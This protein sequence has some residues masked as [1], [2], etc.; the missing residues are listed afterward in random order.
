[1]HTCLKKINIVLLLC[2]LWP[3]LVDGKV[4]QALAAAAAR[5]G[6]LEEGAHAAGRAAPVP[7][8]LGG[9]AP[10]PL[11]CRWA[12]GRASWRGARALC[13]G[14]V[15]ARARQLGGECRGGTAGAVRGV[16][17]SESDWGSTCACT[18][19]ARRFLGG[20]LALGQQMGCV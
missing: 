16:T 5:R 17:S 9:P 14:A 4:G 10:A 13:S 7:R 19:A 1:M 20:I 3:H 15:R 18:A 8:K 11:L 12:G 6:R 2:F